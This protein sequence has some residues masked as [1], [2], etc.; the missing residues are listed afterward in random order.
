MAAAIIAAETSLRVVIRFLQEDM[1]SQEVWPLSESGE[2]IDWLKKQFLTSLQRQAR[3]MHRPIA[4]SGDWR[5]KATAATKLGWRRDGLHCLEALSLDLELE[6]QAGHRLLLVGGSLLMHRI[7]ASR[8][9]A[10]DATGN[11]NS[12]CKLVFN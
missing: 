10:S 4:N 12:E 5:G 7:D 8:L 1:R 3:W 9:D 6:H 2:E 11:A